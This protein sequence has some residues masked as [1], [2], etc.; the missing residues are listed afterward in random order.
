LKIWSVENLER[1]RKHFEL[2]IPLTVAIIFAILFITFGSPLRAG[3]VLL[4]IPFAMVGSTLA[5]YM[6]GMHLSVSA[7]V[8]L[9]SLFGVASMHGVLMVSYIQQLMEEGVALDAAIIR[10]A[11]LRLRPVLMTAMVAILGL[12]PAS[13]A[14]GVG[15]DVQRPIATVVVWGLFSSAFLTLFVM[16]ALYKLVEERDKVKVLKHKKLSDF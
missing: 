15:S 2:L 1:A 9:T 16:P 8:G 6:R 13:L 11:S 10:G 7:G 14:T 3:L 5:L 4:A 12:I